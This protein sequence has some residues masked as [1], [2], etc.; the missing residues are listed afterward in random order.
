M[1]ASSFGLEITL[2]GCPY[3]KGPSGPLPCD[4]PCMRPT[5]VFF[6]WSSG[7]VSSWKEPKRPTLPSCH[8]SP[9]K[10]P[11]VEKVKSCFIPLSLS[12]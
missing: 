6:Y 4:V 2:P 7:G 1:H 8:L 3:P 12:H 5:L 9:A 10:S 11:K